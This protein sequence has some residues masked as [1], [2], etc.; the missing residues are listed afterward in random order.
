MKRWDQVSRC[1]SFSTG[2]RCLQ[3]TA[4]PRGFLSAVSVHL[5]C[6]HRLSSCHWAAP[7]PRHTAPNPAT[8]HAHYTR[9]RHRRHRRHSR[10]AVLALEAWGLLASAHQPW[11]RYSSHYCQ[12]VQL[13]PSPFNCNCPSVLPNSAWCLDFVLNI[14]STKCCYRNSHLAPRDKGGSRTRGF[15][16]SSCLSRPWSHLEPSSLPHP[17]QL[18]LRTAHSG[19]LSFPCA[20]FDCRVADILAQRAV[21]CVAA[22]ARRSIP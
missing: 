15:S 18:Q 6:A 5:P 13:R 20:F 7:V 19:A 12:R 16:P 22:T 10:H 9:R 17:S 21:Y 2:P 14:M 11:T 3:T 4:G 1:R 8:D